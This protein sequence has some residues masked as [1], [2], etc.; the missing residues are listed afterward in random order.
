MIKR[1]AG[2]KMVNTKTGSALAKTRLLNEGCLMEVSANLS[3][4]FIWFSW[5]LTLLD[6]S[7]P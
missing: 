6:S 2:K 7:Y 1:I 5:L 4:R 3:V